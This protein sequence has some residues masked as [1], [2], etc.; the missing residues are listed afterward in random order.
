MTELVPA[1]AYA[2]PH[3]GTQT[4]VGVTGNLVGK[5][6]HLVEWVELQVKKESAW[7]RIGVKYPELTV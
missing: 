1:W 6:A 2:L 3:N 5:V 7:N 4:C